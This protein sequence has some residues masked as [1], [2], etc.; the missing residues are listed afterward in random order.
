MRSKLLKETTLAYSKRGANTNKKRANSSAQTV[1]YNIPYPASAYTFPKEA[2]IQSARC[3]RN[4]LRIELTDGRVLS[5]PLA[6]IPSVRN[7]APVERDKY[8]ISH[9]R[10]MIIWDP[11]K[12]AINDEVRL[13]DYLGPQKK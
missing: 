2:L 5:I 12:C 4:Y 1:W 3:D 9:D 11:D 10:R 8:E 7:A 6:W 13:E